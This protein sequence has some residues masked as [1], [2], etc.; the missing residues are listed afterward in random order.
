MYKLVKCS[1]TVIKTLSEELIL[2]GNHV[3]VGIIN[4]FKQKNQWHIKYV[5]ILEHCD[6]ESILIHT[7]MNI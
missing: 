7:S 5:R 6:S 2:I 1:T 3:E 4:I